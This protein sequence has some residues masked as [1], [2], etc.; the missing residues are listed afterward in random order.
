[1]SCDEPTYCCIRLDYAHVC[2]ELDAAE[3][4]TTNFEITTPFSKDPLRIDV[5]YEW[6]PARCDKCRL[7]GHICPKEK[8]SEENKETNTPHGAWK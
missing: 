5:E 1:M 7:F 3:P 8:L 6:R 2:V 4:Y